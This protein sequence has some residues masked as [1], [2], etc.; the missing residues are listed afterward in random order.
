MAYYNPYI[1]LGSLSSAIY[2]INNQGPL[3]HYSHDN[4]TPKT[5]YA[6]KALSLGWILISYLPRWKFYCIQL[7]LSF[8]LHHVSYIDI[9][10]GKALTQ[11]QRTF[12]SSITALVHLFPP[13]SLAQLKEVFLSVWKSNSR[14]I[15]SIESW[16]VND[17]ILKNGL[18]KNPYKPISGTWIIIPSWSAL[19]WRKG[20]GTLRFSWT[21]ITTWATRKKTTPILSIES[22]LFKV[23]GSLFSWFIS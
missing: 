15:C 20:G 17:G 14:S 9:L 21:I 4:G 3:F 16:L 12:S 1:W 6:A 22:W 2:P 11:P 18:W 7:A 5:R 19:L 23:P 8:L 13:Q 10:P